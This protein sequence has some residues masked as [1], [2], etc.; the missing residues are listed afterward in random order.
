MQQLAV[1][2]D[3]KSQ[4][5][6]V[7]R[8]LQAVEVAE[9]AV[10]APVRLYIYRPKYVPATET[11][12]LVQGLMGKGAAIVADPVGNRLLIRGSDAQLKE[13]QAVLETLDQPPKM[14]AF[15]ILFADVSVEVKEKKTWTTIDEE[16]LA[17][18]ETVAAK[19]KGGFSKVRLTALDNQATM[20][21]YGEETPI[22]T[23]VQA[24]PSRG[25]SSRTPILQRK[26]TGTIVQCTARILEDDTIIAAFEIE[27]S[28]LSSKEEAVALEEGV[29][30][31]ALRTPAQLTTTC[32]TTLKLKPGRPVVVS[33]LKTEGPD[34]GT[35]N[36]II[37]TAELL[38]AVP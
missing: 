34:T 32:K 10:A 38:P 29:E 4:A 23:G 16:W 9:P 5:Q 18:I 27:R 26:Q 2:Q 7:L 22:V 36:V 8:E 3:Q 30:K 15:E 12:T 28:R 14:V 24:F 11:Q 13:I 31:D 35:K 33:G 21:Q 1:G 19:R 37:V 6:E 17:E 25:G 20:V